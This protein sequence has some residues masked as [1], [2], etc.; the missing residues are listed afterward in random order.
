MKEII[1]PVA[2]GQLDGGKQ[3]PD[4]AQSVQMSSAQL[5][6]VASIKSAADTPQKPRIA[7]TLDFPLKIPVKVTMVML[8]F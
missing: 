7:F 6:K 4:T 8:P 3:C 5:T 1:H 2:T